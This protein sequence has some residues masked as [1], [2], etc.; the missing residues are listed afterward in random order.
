[1]QEK[2]N[3]EDTLVNKAGELGQTSLELWRL[4]L[5]DSIATA[6]SA[7][8]TSGI[9]IFAY[10]LF[11]LFIGAG[12]AIYLGEITG[13]LY[14]GFC[15]VAGF[16]LLLGLLIQIAFSQRLKNKFYEIILDKYFKSKSEE[17]V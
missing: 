3:L 4:K 14:I 16:Y 1:M 13:K 15:L 10:L 5:L 2:S 11:L 9:T 17:Q 6:A 12:V 8:M 7:L